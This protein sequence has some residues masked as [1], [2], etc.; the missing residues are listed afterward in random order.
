MTSAA[1]SQAALLE[2]VDE[3]LE[4]TYRSADLGNLDDPLAETIYILLSKQTREAVYRATFRD[5]RRRYVRWLDALAATDS[6]LE[7]VLA[8]CGFQRQ[9]ANQLKAL[10]A[11]VVAANAERGVGPAAPEP[12]DLTLEFLRTM[13]DSDAEQFLT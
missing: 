12:G 11:A 6:E 13:T 1:K 7:R 3:L 10:L 9:R 2:R 4:V 8:P 5:L